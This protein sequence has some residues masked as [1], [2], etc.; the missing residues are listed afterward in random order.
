MPASSPSATQGPQRI[1]VATPAGPRAFHHR[2]TV[3]DRGVVGQTFGHKPGK[4]AAA[5]PRHGR[6]KLFGSQILARGRRPLILDL[7]ANIG[8]TAMRYAVHFPDARVIALEPHEGNAELARRNTAGLDVD[9]RVAAIGPRRGEA[10]IANPDGK[11]WGFRVSESGTGPAVPVTTIPALIEEAG[12][13]GFL[14]FILKCDVEGTERDLF[15]ADSAWFDDF[16]MVSCEPHDW[17]G[18][19]WLTINGFLR[20]H[21][22][23]PRQLLIQ[24]DN[25]LSLALPP[26][27]G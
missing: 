26:P 24:G 16:A 11:E 21:L 9:V 10:R 12:Q 7:G 3:A 6:L 8:A 20:A 13:Q 15:D 1:L 23:T 25:L 5:P 2:G 22:R 27:E 19:R 17:M 4:V 18:R 14:P